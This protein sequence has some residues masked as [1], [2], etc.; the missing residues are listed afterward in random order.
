MVTH[1]LAGAEKMVVIKKFFIVEKVYVSIRRTINHS[2]FNI[3]KFLGVF[4]TNARKKGG[5]R[6]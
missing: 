3:N 2:T 5:K 6:I 4:T 1:F